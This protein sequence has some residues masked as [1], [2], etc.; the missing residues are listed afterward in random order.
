MVNLIAGERVVPELVQQDFTPEK[1][2][3]EVNRILPDGEPREQMLRSLRTVK[4]RLKGP[5]G[6][7]SAPA[8]A[9]I[10]VRKLL[11]RQAHH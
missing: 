2:V 4:A 10:A 1:V 11:N 8:R 7:M 9:A 5:T 3:A 6:G